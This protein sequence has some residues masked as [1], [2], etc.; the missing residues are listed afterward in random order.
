M[1]DAPWRDWKTLPADHG[2]IALG[3]NLPSSTH[4]D[5]REVLRA[6]LQSLTVAG[7]RIRA[8]ANLYE[9]EPDPPSDQPRFVNSAALVQTAL[10]PREL[11]R[12]LHRTEAEFGRQR[13]YRNEARVLDLD[14]L[15]F[16]EQI[17]PPAEPPPHPER[18]SREEFTEIVEFTLPHPRL[19]LRQFVLMPL[20][21]LVPYWIHPIRGQTVT[22]LYADLSVTQ[23]VSV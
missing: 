3:S 14:L 18:I 7:V 11:L 6:A 16:G 12:L 8:A 2:L 20:L 21:D 9:T 17:S 5:S 22:A 10:T 23:S 15:A 13:Q 4:G 19:H 1:S